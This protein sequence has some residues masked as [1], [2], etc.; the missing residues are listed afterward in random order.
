MA[1]PA[2]EII[3]ELLMGKGK[4]DLGTIASLFGGGARVAR[5]GA[6]DAADDTTVLTATIH[7]HGKVVDMKAALEGLREMRIQDATIEIR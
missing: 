4:A 7:T 2:C 3:R 1:A 6:W 5:V